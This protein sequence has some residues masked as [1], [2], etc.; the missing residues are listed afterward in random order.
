MTKSNQNIDLILASAQKTNKIYVPISGCSYFIENKNGLKHLSYAPGFSGGFDSDDQV[1]DIKK[2]LDSL[3]FDTAFLLFLNESAASRFENFYNDQAPSKYTHLSA[4]QLISLNLKEGKADDILSNIARGT[5]QKIKSQGTP[6]RIIYQ[7]DDIFYDLYESLANTKSFSGVYQYDKSDMLAISKENDI[8]FVG[9]EVDKKVVAAAFFRFVKTKT[10]C[11]MDY[12][13]SA[14]LPETSS[15]WAVKVL[16]HGIEL[17]LNKGCKSFNFGGGVVDEDS[18]HH[19]K[20]GFGG[21]AEPFFR[22]RIVNSKGNQKD[23]LLKADILNN[24]YFP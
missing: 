18:L 20:L 6:Y 3:D 7:Y 21:S 4:R 10:N 11:R 22:C 2:I 14:S 16:W 23:K 12:L 24:T 13:L 5:R 17:A 1:K 19:F 8:F 9:V 15:K